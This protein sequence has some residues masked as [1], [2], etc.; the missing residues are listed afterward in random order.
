MN[1]KFF[2]KLFIFGLLLLWLGLFLGQFINLTTADL[3]RHLKNGEVFLAEFFQHDFKNKVLSKNFYSY[4]N[5]DFSFQNHHWGSGIIFFI[6]WQ[7]FGFSGLSLFFIFLY[8]VTFSIFFWIAN[9]KSNFPITVLFSILLIPLIGDRAEIRPEVFSYLFSAIFVA[10][11]LLFREQKISLKILA[12][13]L[14]FLQILWVNLHIYFVFG[15]IILTSFILEEIIKKQP[16]NRIKILLLCLLLILA[17]FFINPQGWQIFNLLFIFQNYGY[18]IVENQSIVFL[19]KWGLSN[20]NFFLY[21]TA[22]LL[23]LIS[24]I[25]V[26]I[27]KWPRPPLFFYLPTFFL[28]ALAFWSIRNFSLFALF[29]LPTFSFNSQVLKNWL[30]GKYISI[31]QMKLFLFS[32]GVAIVFFFN[33][34]SQLNNFS[35]T[36]GNA[37]LGLLPGVNGSANFFKENNLSGPIFNNYDIGGYLIFHLFPKEKIFVDNR[38]EA[39]PTDFFQNIYIPLQED[40]EFWKEKSKEYQFNVIFFYRHDATPWGQPFLIK[41]IQDP[42]WSPVFVDNHTIILIKRDGVNQKVIEKYEIPQEY[43]RII[44]SR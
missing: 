20:P 38:P 28:G 8:L 13:S 42:D 40:E 29:A 14:F 34:F 37:G 43:F 32:I 3:G 36:R 15:P 22:A 10:I 12:P 41:R 39:Y 25:F 31:S 17:A 21:K 19:E 18:Q 35:P 44:K 5:S 30:N 11:L 9:K 2:L 33:F 1:Q 23:L 27:K 4:T 24:S 6:V 26:L 16:K 7:L